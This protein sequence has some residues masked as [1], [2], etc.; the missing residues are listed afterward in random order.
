MQSNYGKRPSLYIR[1]VVAAQNHAQQMLKRG[2]H[3]SQQP[4]FLAQIQ[5]VV[6]SVENICHQH[7]TRVEDLPVRTY[8]AYRYLNHLLTEDLPHAETHLFIS[9]TFHKGKTGKSIRVRGLK[10]FCQSLQNHLNLLSQQPSEEWNS[11]SAIQSL[12]DYIGIQS[13]I[14]KFQKYIQA[15]SLEISS[16]S[17]PSL[18]A[19]QWLCYIYRPEV[20]IAHL[21]ALSMIH[22]NKAR[23]TKT[24]SQAPAKNLHIDFEFFHISGLYHSYQQGYLR[25]M[26]VHEAYIFAPESVLE[27]LL[28][29]TQN[30]QNPNTMALI[31]EFADGEKFTQSTSELASIGLSNLDGTKGKYQDLQAIFKRVNR[32]FFDNQLDPPKLHWSNRPTYRKFGHYQPSSDTLVLST[33]LDNFQ[34]PDYVLDFAMYHELLHKHL[35]Y[36][37]INERRISHHTDFRKLERQF[38]QYQQAQDYLNQMGNKIKKKQKGNR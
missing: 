33:S 22:Q 24:R 18:R 25:K 20:M 16:L 19:Y 37:V 3:P 29:I 17:S 9:P 30:Q 1:G 27:N 12:P 6:T 34:I 21:L 26:V 23:L 32:Q 38:P 28:L 36:Y 2:I 31:K 4:A 14:D 35:G 7:K 15:G 5:K 13:T 10:N 8:H 11:T